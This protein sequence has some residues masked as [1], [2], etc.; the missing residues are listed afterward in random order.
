MKQIFRVLIAHKDAD[1][2]ILRFGLGFT[3]IYAAIS[4]WLSPTDWIGFVPRWVEMF[5]SR[6]DFLI[7]HAVLEFILGLG[8]LIG[9]YLP[10]LGAIAALDFFS[11]LVFYGIDAVSFRD[12]GLT[13][14]ALALFLRTLEGK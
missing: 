2:I 12:I 1:L 3:L 8:L 9:K 10:W 11:I 4:I 6:E 14:A 7:S 13:A 5:G